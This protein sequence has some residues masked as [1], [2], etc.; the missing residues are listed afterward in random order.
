MRSLL[1]SIG[2]MKRSAKLWVRELEEIPD[3]AEVVLEG[4]AGKK[5][6]G[7]GFELHRGL[8]H[9]GVPVLDVVSF[10]KNHRRPFAAAQGFN[11]SG[12]NAVGREDV[13]AR[14]RLVDELFA[15]FGLLKH[16]GSEARRKALELIAPVEEDGGRHHHDELRTFLRAGEQE[17]NRLNGFAEAHVVSEKRA[18][19]PADEAREPFEPFLLIGAKLGAKTRRDDGRQVL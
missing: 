19:A 11:L 13:V 9:P 8:R 6:A 18:R 5:N 10:I 4:R 17:R 15:V 12:K 7:S 2:M 14:F 1:R 16:F 3:F